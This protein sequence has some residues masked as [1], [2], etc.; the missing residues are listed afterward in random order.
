[1]CVFFLIFFSPFLIF[2]YKQLYLILFCFSLYIVVENT[3]SSIFTWICKKCCKEKYFFLYTH[4][5]ISTLFVAPSHLFTIHFSFYLG[6]RYPSSILNNYVKIFDVAITLWCIS[7]L[8]YYT[9]QFFFLGWRYPSSIFNK[10]VKFLVF[11][12]LSDAYLVHVALKYLFQY[13]FPIFIVLF[14]LK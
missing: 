8:F 5:E 9:L 13:L 12:L 6:W 10:Y 7:H 1:M 11:L 14:F 2:I 3:C 4:K